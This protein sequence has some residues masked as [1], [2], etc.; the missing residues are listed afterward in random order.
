MTPLPAASAPNSSATAHPFL[1]K[2]HAK[3]RRLFDGVAPRYDFLNHLLSFQLDRAWRRRAVAAL[4]LAR[5]GCYLDA[6]CGTGDLAFA[7]RRRVQAL[8]GGRVVA[9]DFSLNMLEIAHAKNRADAR[10]PAAA[11]LAGDTLR[12]PFAAQ[13]FDG[14]TVGFGIRNVEHLAA[15]LT[16]LRRVLKP[17]GRLVLLEFTRVTQPVLKQLFDFYC[18]RVLPRIGN[19]LS[20]SRERAYSYLQESI[21]RWPAGDVL[22]VELRSCGFRDVR[23]RRLLPG[24]VALHVGVC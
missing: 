7:V 1:D 18:Q 6:C 8:G 22:A 9:S 12:L 14:V 24:N 20:G 13:T 19:W 10:S 17:G 23:W 4:A 15:A 3:I 5:D 11:L 16:E 2:E 21:A